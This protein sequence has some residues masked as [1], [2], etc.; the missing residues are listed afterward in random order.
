MV[1]FI[2]LASSETQAAYLLSMALF[3]MGSALLGT[4]S[5]AVVGDVI[6]GRGGTPISV[7][8][9]A[10]DAGGVSGPLIAG[11]LTDIT[12]YSFAFLVTAG[13]AGVGA[14]FAALMPETLKRTAA[15]SA[16][17]EGQAA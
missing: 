12:S 15:P 11:Y 10:S 14:V 16:Q 13:I 1:S 17:P 8:Q 2:I 4:T 6:G 3:G 9:M 5:V 7:F